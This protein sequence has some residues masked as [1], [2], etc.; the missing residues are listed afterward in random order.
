M[1]KI[2]I[3]SGDTRTFEAYISDDEID[4]QNEIVPSLVMESAFKVYKSSSP[5]GGELLLLHKNVPVG[6]LTD[7]T[8]VDLNG[9]K[10]FKAVGTIYNDGRSIPDGVWSEMNKKD[11]LVP[12]AFS[13]GAISV[14]NHIEVINNKKIT[15]HDEIELYEVSVICAIDGFPHKPANPRALLQSTNSHGIL[16]KMVNSMD[17]IIKGTETENPKSDEV[18]KTVEEDMTDETTNK[19]FDEVRYEASNIGGNQALINVMSKL[20]HEIEDNNTKIESL[21]QIISKKDEDLKVKNDLI[22]KLQTDLKDEQNRVAAWKQTFK[23]TM[24]KQETIEKMIATADVVINKAQS[25]IINQTNNT[26]YSNRLTADINLMKEYQSL[27]Y[28]AQLK[29]ELAKKYLKAAERLEKE[30]IVM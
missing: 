24:N 28:D 12:V 19:I 14:K 2:I 13:I 18:D 29:P 6:K 4:L 11:P 15:V 21:N 3:K 9:I 16:V 5:S 27:S 20:K 23:E 26:S 30:G 7:F 25:P 22:I 17:E 8:I 10:T 1:I